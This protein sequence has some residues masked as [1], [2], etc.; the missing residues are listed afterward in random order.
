MD[1]H[2]IEAVLFD[3]D[4][5]LVDSD[6]AVERA[7]ASWAR[8]FGVDAGETIAGA[9]GGPAATTVA[10]MRPDLD[11]AGVTA[12][13]NRQ[14]QL[15]YTDVDDVV[16]TPGA[17]DLLAALTLPWTIVTSADV[18]LATARLGA[19]GIAVP[20]LMVTVE[21]VHAGKPDPEGFLLGAHR[22]GV[23]PARCLVVEDS[24]PGIAAGQAA[25]MP[26][27]ALRSLPADLPIAT[28]ADLTHRVATSHRPGRV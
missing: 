25:G 8:E 3:M 23:E 22:L 1:L 17:L 16:A 9:H 26:V 19:A 4:G 20:A 21:D 15:Q 6:A 2:A 14:L 10:R 12:A 7:W 24:A 18:R 28:L 13:A 5:T 11:P 27:A